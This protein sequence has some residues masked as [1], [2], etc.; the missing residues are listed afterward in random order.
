MHCLLS[1]L[2]PLALVTAALMQALW[3]GVGKRRTVL[4]E[5]PAVGGDRA[6]AAASWR[7]AA[8]G[9]SQGDQRHAAPL[10]RGPAVANDPGRIRPAHRAVQTLERARP[11]AA[12]LCGAGGLR[13]PAGGRH[14][15]PHRDSCAPRSSR[16]KRGR[17]NQ[18]I[19]RSRGSPNTKLHALA[20]GQ[21]RLHALLL[22]PGQTH[23]IH[24][25]RHL[26][27]RT[28]AP[29]IL[30]GD[31]ADDADDLRHVRAAQGTPAV[32]QWTGWVQTTRSAPNPDSPDGRRPAAVARP[33]HRRPN[34]RRR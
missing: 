13:R 23:D 28:A 15:G 14:G 21:G 3:E 6:A 30:I 24:G 22:T 1:R 31:K 5:R 10:Q 4:A 17:P 16:R 20:D 19:G 2:C 8:G 12:A 26:L 34:D 32:R 11:V 29:G 18:A 27:A 7:Q 33:H 25:A 9:R